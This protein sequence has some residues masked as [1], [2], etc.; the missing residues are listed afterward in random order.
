[1]LATEIE[2]DT[3]T[4]YYESS[5]EL[6]EEATPLRPMKACKRVILEEVATPRRPRKAC[7]RVNSAKKVKASSERTSKTTLSKATG[8]SG[9]V[10]FFV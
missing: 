1:M 7:K 2:G 9:L 3:K 8:A 6:E 4:E 10:M 5:E